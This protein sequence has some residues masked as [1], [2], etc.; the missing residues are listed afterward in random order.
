[1][2]FSFW[3]ETTFWA[4]NHQW[5]QVNFYKVLDLNEIIKLET[6]AYIFLP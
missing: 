3:S 1:M 5:K 4:I 6:V 2:R